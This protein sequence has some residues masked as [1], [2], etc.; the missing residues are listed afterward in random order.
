MN[1]T[2]DLIDMMNNEGYVC[3]LRVFELMVKRSFKQAYGM[4]VESDVILE[5][6]KCYRIDE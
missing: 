1:Y 4:F 2:S 5:Q 3:L 6:K